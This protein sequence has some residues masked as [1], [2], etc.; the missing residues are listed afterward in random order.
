MDQRF[1]AQLVLLAEAGELHEKRVEIIHRIDRITLAPRLGLA[2]AAQRRLQRFMRVLLARHQIKLHLGRH[3]GLQIQP[4]I[5]SQHAAQHAARRNLH[6]AAVPLLAIVNH[7]GNRLGGPGH[8]AH[9]VGVGQAHHVRIGIANKRTVVG[10]LAIHGIEQ[11]T[12]GQA[13]LAGR[14]EQV[15]RQDLAACNAGHIRD[16]TFH[17]MDAVIDKEIFEG[18]G[19]G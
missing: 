5:Q 19:H 13:H 6:R 16:H 9:G 7:H 18:L 15:T 11:H 3:D 8:D 1:H 17:F 10:L 4:L 14:Q 12:F 2:G